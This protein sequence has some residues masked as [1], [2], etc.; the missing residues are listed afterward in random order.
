MKFANYSTARE[1]MH[2]TSYI[3]AGGIPAAL[4]IGGP[5]AT[6]VDFTLGLAIPLHFHVGMR[7]VIVDY[8]HDV[9]TQ[10]MVLAVLAGVTVLTALGLTKFNL[11]DV[12]LTDG[13]KQLFVEQKPPVAKAAKEYQ[14][15]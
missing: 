9:T 5:V 10:Q 15:K 6:L 4:I 8:V 13:F 12:G 11:M 3:L 2:Y 7:S 14:L 1:A